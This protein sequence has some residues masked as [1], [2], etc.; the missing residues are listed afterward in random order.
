MI[1]RFRPDIDTVSLSHIQHGQ[2]GL[3]PWIYGKNQAQQGGKRPAQSPGD[4]RCS[5]KKKGKTRIKKKDLPG[6]RHPCMPDPRQSL[7]Q[8]TQLFIQKEDAPHRQGGKRKKGA[9]RYPQ[10]AADASCQHQH[11]DSPHQY[12]HKRNYQDIEQ[13]RK[14]IPFIK[15]R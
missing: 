11:K 7:C 15:R 4:F 8:Q 12:S 10:A 2:T 1:P 13:N 3:T 6:L 14:E 9:R 5:Q